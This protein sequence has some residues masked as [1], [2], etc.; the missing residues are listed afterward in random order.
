MLRLRLESGRLTRWALRTEWAVEAD[1][2]IV[3]FVGD[4]EVAER[5]DRDAARPAH[6]GR[7]RR[8]IARTLV[9]AC[10][11]NEVGAG[12]ALSE[13]PIRAHVAR[14]GLRIGRRQGLVV[15]EH[16]IVE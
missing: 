5:V 10:A 9:G 8:R 11:G 1:D 16:S 7:A 12:D 4:V 2:A 6:R 14:A 15:L 13:D 3:G